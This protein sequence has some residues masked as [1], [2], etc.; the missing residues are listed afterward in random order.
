M[1]RIA[2]GENV[3]EKFRTDEEKEKLRK[4][5]YEET[6]IEEMIIQMKIDYENREDKK[7]RDYSFVKAKLPKLVVSTFEGTT[8]DWFCFWNQSETEV[9]KQDISP[10]TKFS[11][12]KE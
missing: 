4:I 12:L 9:D 7:L 8:L 1:Q 2:E 3:K 6:K 5:L 10:V 11:Y